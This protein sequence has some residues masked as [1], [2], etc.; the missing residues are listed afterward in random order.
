M[1]D[2]DRVLP[3]HAKNFEPHPSLGCHSPPK[4]ESS[5]FPSCLTPSLP[6]RPHIGE[7]LIAFRQILTKI[8]PVVHICSFIITT[9]LK[10]FIE[11]KS[12][13]TKQCPAE[14]SPWITPPVSPILLK[15][16]PLL[17][18]YFLTPPCMDCPV[19]SPKPFWGDPVDGGRIPSR[20]KK[21][22]KCSFPTPEKFPSPNSIFRVIIQYKL[23]L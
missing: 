14:L 18:S 19:P 5:P 9:Y 8:L 1:G 11:V 15:M 7:S 20:S 10:K 4:I 12:I 17:S 23:Y 22:K 13:S 6:C 16:F 21:K 2:Q 3:T